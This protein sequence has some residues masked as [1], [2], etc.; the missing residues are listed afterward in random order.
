VNVELANWRGVFAAPGITKAQRDELIAAVEKA[1]KSKEWQESLK[2]ND[3]DNF[4]L[5][6][7][8]YAQYVD[9]ENKRLG[10]ILGQLSLGK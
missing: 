7:D 5:S 9:Q 6:G 10:D 1:T 4:W 3:W 8:A 2:K